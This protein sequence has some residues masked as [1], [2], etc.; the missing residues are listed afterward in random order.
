ML[1]MAVSVLR[2]NVTV[3]NKTLLFAGSILCGTLANVF[4][5]LW[6]ASA[7]GYLRFS[8][9]VRSAINF[10]YFIL[11][12][13]CA[14]GWYLYTE[15]V[16]GDVDLS[17][18]DYLR[19]ASPLFILAVILVISQFNGCVFYFDEQGIYHRGFLFYIQHILSYGYIMCASALCLGRAL[20][21]DNILHR[22]ELFQM[23]TFAVP[24]VICAFIQ[25]FFQKLPILSVGIVI[26]FLVVL[27]QMMVGM[28]SNDE[29]TQIPCRKEMLRFLMMETQSMRTEEE[30]Y[31]MFIDLNHFKKINDE[32]GHHEGDHALKVMGSVL[33]DLKDEMNGFAAR[34]GGDEFAFAC[35]C[36]TQEKM[37]YVKQKMRNLAVEKSCEEGLKKNL[38]LSIGCA[39]YETNMGIQQL[40]T[41]ADTAMYEDKKRERL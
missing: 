11:L 31:F 34:F 20:R 16:Y 7:N 14:Y 40:I 36:E 32:F 29:L 12:G 9:D 17:I 38:S 41:A 24:P 19:N 13:M 21:D 33:K 8:T 22:D 28:I 26:S 39:K 37:E 10:C 2:I 15:K 4:D 1:I 3:T 18:K 25:V 30:L 5:F 27:L 6:N 23:A 35:K